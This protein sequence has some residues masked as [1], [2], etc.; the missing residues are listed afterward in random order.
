MKIKYKDMIEAF[1][2]VEDKR[3][4]SN[5][6]ILEA[7][8]E[9]MAKAYK[10][11]AELTDIDVFATINEKEKTIDIYQNYVVVEEVEDDELEISLEDAKAIKKDAQLGDKIAEKKEITN[12]SRAAANLAKSVVRQK[13]REAE[14]DAVYNEYI[15]QLN[16][17]VFGVVESVKPKFI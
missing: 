8:T 16:D 1:A 11:D 14:K 2:E 17:L 9:A 13:I 3:N 15:S 6:V 5:E 10:K 4:I 12:M 7:L